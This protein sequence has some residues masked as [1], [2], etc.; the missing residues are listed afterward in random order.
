MALPTSANNGVSM[1]LPVICIINL[2]RSLS[3]SI[4]ENFKLIMSEA[5]KPN[6]DANKIIA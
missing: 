3:K 1:V 4:S 6:L 2:M 5:R